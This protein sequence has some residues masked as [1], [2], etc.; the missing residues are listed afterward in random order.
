MIKDLSSNLKRTLLAAFVL[1]PISIGVNDPLRI[2]GNKEMINNILKREPEFD[3]LIYR[4]KLALL[5]G[6]W[7][8]WLTGIRTNFHRVVYN[9]MKY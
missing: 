1:V 4:P 8:S 5:S 2:S 3:K 7:C 6:H 9:P